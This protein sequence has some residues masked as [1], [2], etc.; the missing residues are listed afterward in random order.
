MPSALHDNH[1]S[2]KKCH[3]S[4]SDSCMEA[5]SL[6][7]VATIREVGFMLERLAVKQKMAGF[8]LIEL[9]V[10][11]AIVGILAAI[12]FPS[13]RDYVRRG[14]LS[15]A[16]TYL[17]DFKIK[18]EQF[19]QDNRNYGTGA[20]GNDG[21][22]RVNFSPTGINYFTFACT[23]GANGQSYTLTATGSSG[24]ASGHVY[25]LTSDNVKGTTAFKGGSVSKSCWL[26]KG[27]EC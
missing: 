1:S 9:L 24:Q 4:S 2:A 12:A 16:P 20:C 18:M 13:Y 5:R 27:D 3:W 11:V 21:T 22:Q 17:A 26:M 19:Y 14:T 23:L 10:A 6:S 25:T 7:F 8:T 15:E